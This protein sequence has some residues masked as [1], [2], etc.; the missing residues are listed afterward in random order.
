[1]RLV[2]VEIDTVMAFVKLIVA[3]HGRAS[4]NGSALALS[5]ALDLSGAGWNPNYSSSQ[6]TVI[7]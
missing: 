5:N 7:P 3:G 6:D 4:A 1:M 2:Q